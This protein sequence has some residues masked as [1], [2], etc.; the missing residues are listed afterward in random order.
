[1][2]FGEWC[3]ARHSLGYNVLPDWF[4]LFDVYDRSSGRFWSTSR[5]NALV[6]E[7]GLFTVPLVSSGC[8]TLDAF[9]GFLLVANLNALFDRFLIS[10]D[11]AGHL[12]ISPRLSQS[13]LH[14]LGIYP[15]MTLRWLAREHHPY[16]R[17]HRAR[18]L[19]GA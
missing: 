5:R 18:F 2:L 11:D 4:L 12:L 19:L 14:G 3:A 13:D 16:L 1:M 10:F 17:W 8:A 6:A 7:A 9:N 15:S